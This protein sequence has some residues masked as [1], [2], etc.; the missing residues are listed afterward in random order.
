MAVH[1][2]RFH[3]YYETKKGIL[4]WVCA[5]AGCASGLPGRRHATGA[6]CCTCPAAC[7]LYAHVSS[8]CPAPAVTHIVCTNLLH[9]ALA[10]VRRL[11]RPAPAVTH[12]VCAN[13]PDFK[14]KEY[15]RA[16]QPCP[17]V[18]PE[19]IVDSIAAGQRL[20]VSGRVGLPW[21]RGLLRM[22]CCTAN[23]DTS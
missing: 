7:Q 6:E 14:V 8:P 17:V 18:R 13:L 20:P 21:G 23:Q 12:I 11:S 19:W 9:A 3:N 2:G 16:R 15:E 5:A 4:G 22:P 10:A 1:G